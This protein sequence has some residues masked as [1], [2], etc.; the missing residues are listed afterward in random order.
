MLK[1]DEYSN[2]YPIIRMERRNG[3]LLMTTHTEGAPLEWSDDSKHYPAMYYHLAEAF[4][5]IG[6]DVENKLIIWTGAGNAFSGPRVE[7]GRSPRRT[8]RGWE[9]SS[10]KGR[11]MLMNLLD[12]DVPIICAVNGPAVRHAEMPL[13][14]DIVL[15]SDDTVFQDG[16]HLLWGGVPGDGAHVVYPYLMG[17][18]RARYFLLTNQI[19]SA[20]EALAM[21]LI[22]EVLPKEKLLARAWELAEHLAEKPPLVLRHTRTLLI[23]AMRREM[24]DM[25]GYGLALEGLAN[26]DDR[27]E[28]ILQRDFPK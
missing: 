13:M 20:Q 21:G 7:G 6:S 15:A 24:H 3:I 1:F 23:H 18:N 9:R 25:L 19:I 16:S 12:I 22:A 5:D 4:N 17:L 8:S 2:K 26:M 10:W 11:H 27:P 28:G 14:C